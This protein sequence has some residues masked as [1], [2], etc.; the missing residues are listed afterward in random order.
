MSD[1]WFVQ[2]LKPLSGDLRDEVHPSR[3]V[4]RA[5]LK[6]R[7]PDQWRLGARQYS[8]DD[9]TLTEVSQHAL[10]C[11]SCQ[12]QLARMRHAERSREEILNYLRTPSAVFTHLKIFAAAMA[13]LF[14]LN[15]A[16]LTF[17]PL[18][19]P[20]LSKCT[21]VKPPEPIEMGHERVPPTTPEE[22][23]KPRLCWNWPT[24]EPWRTWWAPWA[25]LFWLLFLAVHLL[26]CA[27]W[28][29]PGR[30]RRRATGTPFS[31]SC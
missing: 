9:W 12:Q 10:V 1:E 8:P 30:Q 14:A 24:T 27:W 2:M 25:F 4:L 26:I 7:L 20:T 15:W 18:P 21:Q 29:E 6:G 11:T 23:T 22:Y 5:Y 16:M 28:L 31:D 13:L 17:L 19:Q 3:A